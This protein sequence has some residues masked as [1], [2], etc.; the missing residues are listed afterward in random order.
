MVITREFL[1]QYTYLESE[2]RRIRRKL[3]YYENHPVTGSHG[4]VAGSMTEFPYA[5]C[6]FVVGP[7]EVKSDEQRN[8]VVRQL[9]IDLKGNERL[10]EDMKLDIELF[11]ESESNLKMDL[12]MK[13]ILRMKYVD[14]M[15]DKAIAKKMGYDRST[16]C[17]K[18][19]RF[20]EQY[21]AP[22]K[23]E[24]SHNSHF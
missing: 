23:N 24:V 3:K 18:I 9:A 22:N 12:E 6:H 2:L 19:D 11:L 21:E 7:A 8:R 14:G 4:V 17:K 20:L 1:A 15:K 13:E 10:Y 5:E 16:I